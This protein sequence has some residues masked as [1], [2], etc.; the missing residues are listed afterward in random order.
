MRRETLLEGIGSQ[1]QVEFG[2]LDRPCSR[3]VRA[4]DDG[5]SQTLVVHRTIVL[6]SAIAQV[7]GWL[8]PLFKFLHNLLVVSSKYGL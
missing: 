3:D 8:L 4:V 6:I 5:V 7:L 2:L 1:S